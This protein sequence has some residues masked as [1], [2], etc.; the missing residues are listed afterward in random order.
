LLPCQSQRLSVAA[1]NAVEDTY[2]HGSVSLDSSIHRHGS[3]TAPENHP[4]NSPL[5]ILPLQASHR[6][7]VRQSIKASICA[8][9]RFSRVERS[10]DPGASVP[11]AGAARRAPSCAKGNL[12]SPCAQVPGAGR[13]TLLSRFSPGPA[14]VH[15][16]NPLRNLRVLG[17]SGI[18]P[19]RATFSALPRIFRFKLDHFG[20]PWLLRLLINLSS[21]CPLAQVP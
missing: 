13:R 15:R 6:A 17:K 16:S 8:R 20:T 9:L 11:D 12:D 14:S 10:G 4:Q 3:E 19:S 5:S 1:V 2:C 18:V 7:R 21:S